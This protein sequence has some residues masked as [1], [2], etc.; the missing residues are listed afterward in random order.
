MTTFELMI[1]DD[2]QD[3]LPTDLNL[4]RP[5]LLLYTDNY[6]NPISG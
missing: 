5:A 2:P 4:D 1:G 3:V 6:F